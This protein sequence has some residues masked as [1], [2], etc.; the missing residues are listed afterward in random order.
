MSRQRLEFALTTVAILALWELA[1][2]LGVPVFI[3]PPPHRIVAKL[4]VIYPSVLFHSAITLAESI[5]GF[6]LA[7]SSASRWPSASSTRA[8]WSGRCTP[9]W[10]PSG[11]SP[12]SRWRR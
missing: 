2:W 7:S 12:S 8:S 10:S 6:V 11:S 3:L 4:L 9:T 5:L 1:P